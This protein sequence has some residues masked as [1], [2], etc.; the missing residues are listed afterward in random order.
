MRCASTVTMRYLHVHLSPACTH[1]SKARAGSAS[2]GEVEGALRM[3]RWCLELVVDK[4]Y[5]SWSLETVRTP[6]VVR[7]VTEDGRAV[8]ARAEDV[9]CAVTRPDGSAMPRV[10]AAP[11]RLHHVKG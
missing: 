1:L 8:E 11:P 7:L 10:A 4:G 5:S 2:Q 9:A 3:V 6:A